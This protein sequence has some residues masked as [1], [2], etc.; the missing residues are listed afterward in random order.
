[1]L[2]NILYV[3]ATSCLVIGSALTFNYKETPDYFYLVGS[4]LFLIKAILSLV[5]ETRSIKSKS[6]YESI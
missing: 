4:S 2:S 3:T 1:M 6:V 5:N